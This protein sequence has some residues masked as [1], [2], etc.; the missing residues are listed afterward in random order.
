VIDAI[1]HA[2]SHHRLRQRDNAVVL[3]TGK[4]ETRVRTADIG[5]G[6]LST[7]HARSASIAASIAKHLALSV[8]SVEATMHANIRDRPWPHGREHFPP[9][10]A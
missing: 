5:D 4:R 10:D 8:V 7:L 6:D 9:P 2:P 3:D 1:I